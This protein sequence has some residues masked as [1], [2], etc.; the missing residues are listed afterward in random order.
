MEKAKPSAAM[1]SKLSF[2]LL[3]GRSEIRSPLSQLSGDQCNEWICYLAQPVYRIS[4]GFEWLLIA[5]N[6]EIAL[7]DD[8]RYRMSLE[9]ASD[10]DAAS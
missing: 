7:Y 10:P 2:M 8:A 5:H 6:P 9:K 3:W 4:Q 1:G